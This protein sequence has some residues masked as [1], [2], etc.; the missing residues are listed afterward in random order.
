MGAKTLFVQCDVS[1]ANSVQSAVD[2]AVAE[3][4]RLDIGVNNAGIGGSAA[5]AGDYGVDEW[6]RVISINLD[7]ACYCMR[8]E[9]PEMRKVGAGEIEYAP[10]NIRVVAVNPGSIETPLPK[11]DGIAKGPGVYEMMRNLR[12]IG[13]LGQPQE[14]ANPVAWLCSD[15]ASFV[16]G[17]P[18]VVDGGYTAQS[19]P[20]RSEKF[21]ANRWSRIGP[22]AYPD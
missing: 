8:S 13:R 14:I 6:H 9:V 17:V 12:P 3:F 21:R 18:M 15:E 7:G 20:L 11:S 4:G 16:T 22:R 5:A 19:P 10:E 1:D 2:A